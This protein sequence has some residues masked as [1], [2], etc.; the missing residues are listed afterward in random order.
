MTPFEDRSFGIEAAMTR[1]QPEELKIDRDKLMF[2]AGRASAE[3]ENRSWFWMPSALLMTI[4]AIGLLGTQVWGRFGNTSQSDRLAASEDRD[5][6]QN[7]NEAD[8][9]GRQSRRSDERAMVSGEPFFHRPEYLLLRNRVLERGF[10][11]RSSS[12]TL[13]RDETD[14]RMVPSRDLGMRRML[15]TQLTNINKGTS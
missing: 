2:L 5:S 9:N 10:E 3:R 6:A 8:L 14:I 11:Y 13:P 4:V 15:R 1:L 12:A 7:M